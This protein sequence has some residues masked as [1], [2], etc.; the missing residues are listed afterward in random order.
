[1][2]PTAAGAQR[3]EQVFYYDTDAIGSVRA[4]T[5]ASGTVSYYDFTPF[6]D[7]SSLNRDG[8]WKH[9]TAKLTRAQEEWLRENGW[10]VPK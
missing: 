9:G 1:V 3:T 4:V 10:T 7:G 2:L 5:N 8:T 6:A